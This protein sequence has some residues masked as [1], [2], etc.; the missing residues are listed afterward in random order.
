MN[1]DPLAEDMRR[2]SPYNY[3][4]DNPIFWTDPD[5]MAPE[6]FK[7]KYKD[8]EGNECTFYFNGSNGGDA[9]KDDFIQDFIKAYDYSV[10]NGE[11]AGN[12]GGGNLKAITENSDINLEVEK[13]DRESEFSSVGSKFGIAPKL[14]WNPSMGV[15]TENG[16]GTVLS[17]ATIADHEAGHAVDFYS[18]PLSEY[19]TIAT[20]GSDSQYNT[21][22]ERGVI[23]G[24]EQNT[25]RANGEISGNQVTRID[26]GGHPV[27]TNSST[28]TKVNNRA[29]HAHL[30]RLDSR[31]MKKGQFIPQ[32]TINRY[33]PKK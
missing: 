3:A 1:L 18:M 26:H 20:K 11:R 13:T 30:K 28:S 24:T 7:F 9:P 27:I 2:H 29:T 5:G 8:K 17:P 31:L 14:L 25:A 19:N 4:F 12:G 22:G 6:D 33:A 10:G 32:K 23:T 16:Q 15:D 21:P